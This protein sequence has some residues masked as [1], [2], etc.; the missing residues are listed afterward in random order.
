MITKLFWFFVGSI[1]YTYVGYPLLLTLLARTRP[2]PETVE[3]GLPSVTLLVAAYN[4]EATIAQKLENSLALNYPGER[5]Q[6]VVA[7]D[8]SN[9][10][11]V[12]IVRRYAE[13]GVELSY[14]PSR[15]GK[16]AAINRAL[17]RVRGE[18]I[19]FSD[20]NNFYQ[21]DTVQALV[22]PFVDPTVGAVSGAKVIVKDDETLSESEGL[23]WKYESFIKRQETRLGCCA[24]VAGE[25]LA[26]RKDLFEPPPDNIINDDFYIAMRLIRRGYRVVYTPRAR[27]YERVSP[28]AR[29]EIARRTRIV[30]GR[31]QAIALAHQLLPARR[32]LVVWQ[33][34]SHKFLRPLVPLAMIG[35]LVTN[36]IDVARSLRTTQ[37]TTASLVPPL[38]RIMLVAQVV[39]YGLAWLGSVNERVGRSGKLL[40][41]PTFLVNS[42]FAAL[43]GLYRFITKSQT[44]RWKRVPRRDSARHLSTED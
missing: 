41:L 19:V 31:Y 25:V 16:I 24:G 14:N 17:A 11:T 7:A 27:S 26:V 33:I 15:R 20:A 12:D 1:F 8:G 5:L 34:V 37:S 21:P 3:S 29:D 18:I 9:D 43:V 23:Y 36:I 22:K 42:N 4:E 38:N 28:S 39:F 2:R 32:P 6:I 40:Y 10:R 35:A 13:R 30:A 44:T